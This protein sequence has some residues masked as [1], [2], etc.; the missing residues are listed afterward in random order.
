MYRVMG[1]NKS[2]GATSSWVCALLLSLI[3]MSGV[4][5]AADEIEP[6][7]TTAQIITSG[8]SIVGSISTTSDKDYYAITTSSAG[9]LTI[10]FQTDVDQF[11]GYEIFIL[12]EPGNILASELCDRDC[13][14][15]QGESRSLSVGLSAAGTFFVYVRSESSFYVPEGTYTMVATFAAGTP[16]GVEIEPNDTTAQIITSG[17]SITGKLSEVTDVD[18]YSITVDGAGKLEVSMVAERKNYSYYFVFYVFDG[19]GNVLVSDYCGSDCSGFGKTIAAGVKAAGI[20]T[21]AV[22]SDSS[23]GFPDGLYTIKM[24]HSAGSADGLE[25]ESNDTFDLAQSIFSNQ[26]VTGSLSSL[27]DEDWYTLA[28]SDSSVIDVSFKSKSSSATDWKISFLDQSRKVIKTMICSGASCAS[29]GVVMN[30]N[31][32][33][34]GSKYLRVASASDSRYPYGGYVLRV[35]SNIL[36]DPPQTPSNL[37]ASSGT[38]QTAIS[39]SWTQG[40]AGDEYVLFRSTQINGEYTELVRSLS[41][42]YVDSNVSSGVDYFYKIQA[43]NLQGKSEISSAVAGRLADGPS[44]IIDLSV[45]DTSPEYINL[46]FTAPSVSTESAAADKYEIRYSEFEISQ[47]NWNGAT[48]FNSSLKPGVPGSTQNIQV[49][50]LKPETTYWFAVKSLDTNDFVSLLS[51]VASSKTLPLISLSQYSFDITLSGT[52]SVVKK[53]TIKNLSSSQTISYTST[54]SGVGTASASESSGSSKNSPSLQSKAVQSN[55]KLPEVIPKDIEEWI[56]KLADKLSTSDR[57][58]L[59]AHLSGLNSTLL[60]DYKAE[61]MQ[62]WSLPIHNTADFAK[63]LEFLNVDKRVEYAEPNYPA[64]LHSLPN[65]RYMSVLW[66]LNNVG[67]KGTGTRYD[68]ATLQGVPGAD[69]D[70]ERAWE[71]TRGS[72]EVIVAV[73]DTGIDYTHPDLVSNV[74]RNEGEIAGNDIDDD[75]NGYID[76]LIGWNYCWNDNDV[77]DDDQHGTHVSGTIAAKAGNDKGI[78]GV[79]PNVKIMTL[80]ILGGRWG[81]PYTNFVEIKRALKYAA[82]NGASVMN[83]SWG[84]AY[85]GTDMCQNSRILNEGIRYAKDRGVLFVHSAGND[86]LN[87]DKVTSDFWNS[88]IDNIISVAATNRQDKLASFSNYGRKTV[89]IGAPGVGILSTIPNNRYAAF[90]GTSMASPHVA[91]AAAL[92][93]SYRPNWGFSQIKNLLKESADPISGLRGRT[94]TGGRLNIGK[95]LSSIFPKWMS[96]TTNDQSILAPGQSVDITFLVSAAG[97]PDGVY[98][99]LIDLDLKGATAFNKSIEI[100][101]NKGVTYRASASSVA[102]FFQEPRNLAV[103]SDITD[104]TI[105]ISWDAVSGASSYQVERA[106]SLDG[107]YAVVST[108]TGNTHSDNDAVSE[109]TYFYRVKS[110]FD[111]G[112]SAASKVVSA[113]RS[114]LKSDISVTSTKL[115]SETHL[116]GSTIE[117]PIKIENKGPNSIAS[118]T[119]YYSVPQNMTHISGVYS[120]GSCVELDR[121]YSCSLGELGINGSK[122]VTVSAKSTLVADEILVFRGSGSIDDPQDINPSNDSIILTTKITASYDLAVSAYLDQSGSKKAYVEVSNNGPS[123]AENVSVTLGYSKESEVTVVPDRGSCNVSVEPFTCDLGEIKSGEVAQILF[124]Q[125]KSED[126]TLKSSISDSFD[127]TTNNNAFTLYLGGLA[128]LDTDNDGQDN[129]TDL[130]DD[131]DGLTDGQEAAYGTNPLLKDSDGDDY[132]DKYEIDDGSDPLDAQSAPSSGLNMSL[133]KAFLDKQ[134]AEQ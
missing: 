125:T 32:L 6:N 101:L 44:T 21:L 115:A 62:L 27:D 49:G 121:S 31:A 50:G 94:V 119:L 22:V 13:V 64:T 48:V 60:R 12:D 45:V 104:L 91:G 117:I 73:F 105:D 55:G 56:I 81:C 93:K 96:I 42:T 113:K 84:C 130:D 69:I 127:S 80:K 70:I 78:V 30:I 16:T 126:A 77:R 18:W 53:L 5:Y 110:N 54:L 87:N 75:R 59:A 82:D 122:V 41:D 98:A 4:V 65:D 109:Q 34:A 134:K 52:Q 38:S 1:F 112:A 100:T 17:E 120:A 85:P 99:G 43:I 28:I 51:N 79:A 90:P 97:L 7:D 131:G 128:D 118:A 111:N 35:T 57:E 74:W 67:Q 36:P 103:T 86:S 15:S 123:D 72:P 108:V 11:S 68:S 83:H 2:L 25:L 95:A 92:I 71:V 106:I 3:C 26:P 24:T 124:T 33:G 61:S 114:D 63:V 46:S 107:T 40:Q 89:D 116:V 14:T 129:N 39:L 58:A 23:F 10:N 8:E 47:V 29:V 102:E 9:T 19:D 76:D 66:G 20:Y 133:I 132:S 37:S 88:D